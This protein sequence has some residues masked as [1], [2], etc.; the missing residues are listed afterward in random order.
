[1]K[2]KLC[3][4]D[5]AESDIPAVSRL[6]ERIWRDY[7]PGIIGAEQ[8]GYML[9]LM[10]SHAALTQL[11]RE[12]V[13]R[14]RLA[15]EADGALAGYLSASEEADGAL[16]IHKFYV[17]TALHGR[18]IGSLLLRDAAERLPGLRRLR[19]HV[20][21]GNARSIEYY[22][23]KGFVIAGERDTDIGGGFAM[24]DFVMEREA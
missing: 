23:R 21:R 4:R 8:I 24:R 22:R 5:M 12:G 14:F 2:G 17:D 16:F 6:A 9:E 10:Y 11:L 15:E 3:L 7:Y 18:G 19:L 20:N 13:Q 1:M